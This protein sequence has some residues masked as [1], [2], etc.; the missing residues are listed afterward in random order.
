MKQ[1]FTTPTA[2]LSPK[3]VK[4]VLNASQWDYEY[5]GEQ[6]PTATIHRI[7]DRLEKGL[8]TEVTVKEYVE[9]AKCSKDFEEYYNSVHLYKEGDVIDISDLVDNINYHFAAFIA[10]EIAATVISE[11]DKYV[12]SNYI[13]FI[14]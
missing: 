8:F 4:A 11:D 7:K 9:Q 2:L 3:E 5:S 12:F 6:A 10:P 1:Q 14:K 13:F